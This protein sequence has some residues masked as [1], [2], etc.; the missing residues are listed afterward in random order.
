MGVVPESAIPKRT[1]QA[2]T[3][4]G[5]RIDSCIELG[6]SWGELAE[7]Q[8]GHGT[9]QLLHV[10]RLIH[11]KERYV[12]QFGEAAND[13]MLGDCLWHICRMIG[14]LSPRIYLLSKADQAVST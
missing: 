13:F 3:N 10:A 7:E 12:A 1:E 14:K 6:S 8:S 2:I 9:R 4:A 11:A 5:L